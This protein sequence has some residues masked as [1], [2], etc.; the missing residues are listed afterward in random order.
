VPARFFAGVAPFKALDE[1]ERDQALDHRAKESVASTTR[2]TNT[3]SIFPTCYQLG[4]NIFEPEGC[5][6]ISYLDADFAHGFSL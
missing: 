4:R 5:P 3:V 1:I 6:Y 2:A